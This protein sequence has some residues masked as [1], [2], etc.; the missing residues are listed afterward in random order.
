MSNQ[1]FAFRY[2]ESQYVLR[3]GREGFNA[4]P[5]ESQAW[6]SLPQQL[7]RLIASN[8]QTGDLL[9]EHIPAPCL[10]ET[11]KSPDEL[12]TYLARLHQIMPKQ[13]CVGYQFDCFVREKVNVL[14]GA[15]VL[16]DAIDQRIRRIS[17]IGYVEEACHN[18]LN[19]WNILVTSGD[20]K[21]WV[22]LDWEW[23]GNFTRLFDAI[24]LSLFYGLSTEQASEVAERCG[25][26][27]ESRYGR[28]ELL[29]E[30]YW[31]REYCFAAGEVAAGR[32]SEFIQEQLDTC[33]TTLADL[34]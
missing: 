30:R 1:N 21:S 15:R 28:F 9:T 17:P 14:R 16:P 33:L 20:P 24:N 27:D 26:L 11:R 3:I 32:D 19:A 18:D 12:A 4:N 22:T 23:A 5:A 29:V 10:A 25:Y 13:L 2:Q 8:W 31:L 34:D 7:P 6:S